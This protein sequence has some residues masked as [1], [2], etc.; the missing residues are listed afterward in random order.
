MIGPRQYIRADKPPFSYV[1]LTA[2]A[3]Q[4][5]ES[6]RLRLYQIYE[7]IV[8]MF[9]LLR[10][11][12]AAWRDSVR[13]NL[14][15]YDCFYV[16]S[17]HHATQN[18]PGKGNFWS[19]IAEKIPEIH[20]K[21]Q[22]RAV[23]RPLPLGV[24][25][26]DDLR[27]VFNFDTGT[28]HVG[29]V[30]STPTTG[31]EQLLMVPS[32]SPNRRISE[33]TPSGYPSTRISNSQPGPSGFVNGRICEPQRPDRKRKMTSEMTPMEEQILSKKNRLSDS[34][35]TLSPPFPIA[36]LVSLTFQSL[37]VV[38][39]DAERITCHLKEIFPFWKDFPKA[40]GLL[41][42]DALTAHPDIFIPINPL[43]YAPNRKFYVFNF[44]A[45]TSTTPMMKQRIQNHYFVNNLHTVMTQNHKKMKTMTSAEIR[46]SL[47]QS[48]PTDTRMIRVN[49]ANDSIST[50]FSDF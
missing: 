23:C 10:L 13:H 38:T 30:Q 31:V 14:P 21:Q 47:M 34:C 39:T 6:K 12:N 9:P 1:G 25:Y 20:L 3:I 50:M 32:D 33:R 18:K 43:P 24:R 40:I 29:N 19:V 7:R 15:K 22:A 44:D 16:N 36:G 27:E 41:V 45:I 8:E 26:V 17:S 11:S 37:G 46:Q 42:Q 5:S 4:S 35:D 28:Y 48:S 49:S 2:M